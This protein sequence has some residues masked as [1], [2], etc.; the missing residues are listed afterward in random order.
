MS[1]KGK[2]D[3]TPDAASSSILRPQEH[4]KNSACDSPSL[5]VVNL[6]R[7]SG[8]RMAYILGKNCNGVG[9]VSEGDCYIHPRASDSEPSDLW[10]L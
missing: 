4:K 9:L 2:L 6:E 5:I 3:A 10:T 1:I 7:T 8:D